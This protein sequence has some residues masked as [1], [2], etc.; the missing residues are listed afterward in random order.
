VLDGPDGRHV[1]ELVIPLRRRTAPAPTTPAAPV[2]PRRL[3]HGLYLPGSEWL[4]VAIPCPPSCQDQV[5]AVLGDVAQDAAGL[6]NQW[7]W[8]RYRN[9]RHGPHLRARFHGDP[10]ALTATVL[11]NL[12]QR[13]ADLVTGR[14]ASGMHVE[15][16]DQEIERYGGDQAISLAE[17]V[18]SAD[19]SLVLTTVA[20]A[21]D[22]DTLITIAALSAASIAQAVADSTRAAVDVGGLDRPARRRATRLRPLTRN[23][24]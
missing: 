20:A 22:D 6:V 7:F 17:A 15:P 1:L 14:L 21:R 11:P 8:L 24:A 2:R 16:Y 19:S 10:A 5:L 9:E 23:A 4:S 12:A 13:C 18:F 3:G